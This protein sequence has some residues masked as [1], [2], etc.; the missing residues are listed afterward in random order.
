M[1]SDTASNALVDE[2]AAEPGLI[3]VLTGAGVSLA[4]GIPTFRGTDEGATWTRDVTEVATYRY[5]RANPVAAWQWYRRRFLAAQG[6]I[7]N[8]AHFALATMERW[9]MGRGRGFLLAT[10]N[11]DALH[12]QAGSTELAKV[13]GFGDR[14]RCSREECR[15]SAT[16][17]VAIVELD[18]ADFDRAPRVE[19]IPRC[20]HCGGVMRPHVLLFDELYTSHDD[21]RWSRV[22]EA[23]ESVGLVIAVGTSFSV[24]VTEFVRTE[25]RRRGAPMFIIDPAARSGFAEVGTMHLRRNAEELLPLVVEGLVSR[26]GPTEGAQ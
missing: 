7:P 10:Q 3:L 22:E 25:A 1:S 19:A 11:V 14:A 2:I 20:H 18:F 16:T 12:E 5:F 4:S 26:G 9:Q 15:L 8:A 6:A 13:H 17:T 23:C 24:G 21:Y